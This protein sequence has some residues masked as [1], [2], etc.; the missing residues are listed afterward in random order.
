VQHDRFVRNWRGDGEHYPRYERLRDDLKEDYVTFKSFLDQEKLGIPRTTQGEI[1]YVNQIVAD[2]TWDSHG[3]A[4]KVFQVC[5]LPTAEKE[6]A[7]EDFG[8]ALRYVIPDKKG[9][10]V[11]RLYVTVGSAFRKTDEK[12]VFVMKLIARGRLNEEGEG[13]VFGFHELGREWIVRRFAALTTP[14]MHRIWGR[15]K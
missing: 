10:P 13:A 15:E 2:E 6:P 7:L 5:S 11:G 8:F 3:D 14:E 1:T 4:H 12:P 9:T